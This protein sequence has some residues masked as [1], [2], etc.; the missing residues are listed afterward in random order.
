MFVRRIQVEPRPVS[1]VLVDP[2]AVTAWMPM[3]GWTGTAEVFEARE[4]GHFRISLRRA[5][6][7]C[8]GQ[9]GPGLVGD[10]HTVIGVEET[11]GCF[12][13]LVPGE[14]VVQVLTFGASDP[15]V[16]GEMTVTYRIA[17]SGAGTVLGVRHEGLPLGV[18]AADNAA[19]WRLDWAGWC[20]WCR[21]LSPPPRPPGVGG[22]LPGVDLRP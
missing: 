2:A 5:A 6:A 15:G 11:R 8:G 18:T 3:G 7:P 14:E 10:G 16:T 9:D 19:G 13:R 17:R 4:G 12:V 1:Q 22:A 20:S 21:P